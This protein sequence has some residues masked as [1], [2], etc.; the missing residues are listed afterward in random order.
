MAKHEDRLGPRDVAL[1]MRGQHLDG[2]GP[3]KLCEQYTASQ[4][5]VH[6]GCVADRRARWHRRVRVALEARLLVRRERER[7][8]V[9]P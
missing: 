7:R 3:C 4:Y 9:S 2:P 8:A 1:L 6:A 5:G